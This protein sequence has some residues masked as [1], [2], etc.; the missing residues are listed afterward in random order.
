M[1]RK[2][3]LSIGRPLPKRANVVLSRSSETELANS[4]WHRDETMLLWAENRES[5]LFFA[6]VLSIARGKPDFFVIGGSEMYKV[7]GDLFNKIYLTEVMTGNAIRRENRDALFE[8]KFDNRKWETIESLSFPAGPQDDYPSRFTVLERRAKT[9]RYVEVQDYYTELQS[10]KAWLRTQ[11]ELF[12]D[13]TAMRQNKPLNVQ[14]Q[15]KW[16]EENVQTK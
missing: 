3:F 14:Y 2:T 15:F 7:F 6:D 1:G 10:K 8:Y 16:F 11:L 5:A 4:F 12:D 13:T 9:V